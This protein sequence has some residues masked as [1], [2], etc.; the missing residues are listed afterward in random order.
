MEYVTGEKDENTSNTSK[1]ENTIA[2]KTGPTDNSKSHSYH[3]NL[4]IRNNG[5]VTMF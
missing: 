2:I 1:T 5:Y 3:T 4:K